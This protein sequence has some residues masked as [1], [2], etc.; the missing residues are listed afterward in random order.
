MSRGD[1]V[2]GELTVVDRD[3]AV[4]SVEATDGWSVMEILRDA[5]FSVSAICGGSL[6]CGT[7]HVY[8]E[9]EIFAGLG[10]P[11]LD[12][13]DLLESSGHYDPDR[14]RLSCQVP[15]NSSLQGA[16]VTIAPED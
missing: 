10:R 5:G 15:F 13:R 2:A 8:F 1:S 4:R 16:R 11:S 14:S 12:E 3:G 6:S 7:C 9:A